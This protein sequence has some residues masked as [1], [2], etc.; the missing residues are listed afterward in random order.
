M[1]DAESKVA[2]IVERF[3]IAVSR[4]DREGIR[5]RHGK[6]LLMYDFPDTVRGIEAYDRTWDFFF[7]QQRGPI[8]F[9][10]SNLQATAGDSVGFVTCE[11][12]CEGTA[13]GP[14][15]FRLTVGLV[16]REGNWEITHEHHSLP[17]GD[18]RYVM[19]EKRTAGAS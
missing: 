10:P 12:H 7:D 14:L 5:A 4:G 15:D 8:T 11:V 17:T 18:E 6:D 19:P 13:A 9:S 16:K 1:N 3:L 2:T